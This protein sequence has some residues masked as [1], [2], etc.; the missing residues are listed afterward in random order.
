MEIFFAETTA[1][2]S[3]VNIYKNIFPCAF[4][5][6]FSFLWPPSFLQRFI[7]FYNISAKSRLYRRQSPVSCLIKFNVV[8]RLLIAGFF[9]RAWFVFDAIAAL[10]R[11]NVAL[12]PGSNTTISI[13]LFSFFLLLHLSIML[14]IRASFIIPILMMQAFAFDIRAYYIAAAVAIQCIWWF[15]AICRIFLFD[16]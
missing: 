11:L 15:P 9:L 1:Q 10:A 13:S 12:G 16:Y 7:Y 8:V 4:L 2:Q 14:F 3:M 6:K 5:K